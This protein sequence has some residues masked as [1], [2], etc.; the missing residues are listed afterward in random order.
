M[1]AFARMRPCLYGS[2]FLMLMFLYG[3]AF[4][5]SAVCPADKRQRLVIGVFHIFG[6]VSNSHHLDK[7][8]NRPTG[9]P[10]AGRE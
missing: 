8:A 4:F 9:D 2:A 6:H 3:S 5:N 7:Q 1:F 10:S